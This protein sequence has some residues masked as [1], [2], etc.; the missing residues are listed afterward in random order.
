MGIPLQQNAQDTA[1]LHAQWALVCL[2]GPGGT[3][4]LAVPEEVLEKWSVHLWRCGFRHHKELQEIKYVP[5]STSEGG[6]LLAP[7]GRWVDM[8]EP[9]APTVDISELSL[10]EKHDLLKALEEDLNG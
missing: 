9:V 8:D 2:P 1:E 7:T 10:Q 3:A 4:P 6:F 5:P